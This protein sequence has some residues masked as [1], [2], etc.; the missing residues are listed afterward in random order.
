[1][2]RG[3]A[4]VFLSCGGEKLPF[5]NLAQFCVKMSNQF[6]QLHKLIKECICYYLQF[7]MLSFA[8]SYMQH[9]N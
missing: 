5:S 6:W 1:M 3:V 9:Y 8:S 7:L 4:E 2:D